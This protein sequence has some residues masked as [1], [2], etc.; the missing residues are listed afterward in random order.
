MR[1]R[2]VGLSVDVSAMRSRPGAARWKLHIQLRSR[3][4][5]LAGLGPLERLCRG[6]VEVGD[7]SLDTRFEVALRGETPAPQQFARQDREPNLDLVQPRRVL[8]DEIETDPVG[9]RPQERHPRDHRLQDAGGPFFTK[10]TV[11][12]TQA[13]TISLPNWITRPPPGATAC[14]GWRA[15]VACALTAG[16]GADTG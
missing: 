14:A 3:D 16:T 9:L 4:Q 1:W 11:N 10:I 12:P 8:G 5:R 13:G 7:E 15:V 2:S 6:R